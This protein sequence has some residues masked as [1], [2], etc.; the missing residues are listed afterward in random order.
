MERYRESLVYGYKFCFC[1]EGVC[2]PAVIAA[3][4]DDSSWETVRVPHDWAANGEFSITNDSSYNAVDADGLKDAIGHTGRTGG[5]PIVGLGVY[6]RWIDVADEDKG[7]A[8]MLEFDGVMWESH[9]YVNGKHAYFNHYGYKSFCVDITDLVEYGKPNL[10]AVSAEV[11]KDCSRWYC[12][13]GIYRNMYLVRKNAAHIGYHGIW[14]RQLEVTGNYANFELSVEHTG[15][16]NVK[17]HANILSPEGEAVTQVA[18]EAC[19]GRLSNI[20]SIPDAKLWDVDSPNL[21]TAVVS[22]LD[23]NDNVLDS[24]TVRFGARSIAFTP[25]KGFFL[26]GRS[27]K[28]K[29]VCLH[30]DLGS[31]G[32]AV[33]VAALR[34][35]LRM[36]QEM[37]ANAIRTSHNPPA[38][39]LLELCDEMGLLVN[40]ELFD[41]W[42]LPKVENGYAQYFRQHAAR[43]AEDIVRRD[44][45]HP[46]VIMW[47]IGNEVCEQWECD[48]WRHAKMLSKACHRA[49]PT[50]PTTAGF[51]GS[52]ASF[53][54][55]LAEYIDV[56]GHNYKPYYYEEFHKNH[57]GMVH[58][59][60][61]TASCVS[62]RGVYKLPA[63]I[64]I[65][66]NK[67]EDLTVS[68]YELE[69]P[70]WA[71][72]P[73]AEFAAQ[74]DHGFLVGEFV[75]SGFD[76][77]GEPTPYYSEWP[78]RSSY[79]GIVDLAGIPKN[80]YYGYQAHWTK[81]P[82]LHIFPHWNWEGMEG[83]TVPVH[84]YTNFAAVELFVNGKSYGRQSHISHAHAGVKPLWETVDEPGGSKANAYD[85]DGSNVEQRLVRRYR[86]IW[87]D[88]VYQPGT[89]KAVAYDEKGNVAA[90]QC[91]H[92]AGKPAGIVLT[93]DRDAICADG[94]DLV[95]ITATVVDEN[96]H[97]CPLADNRLCFSVTGEGELLT[98]DN[99]DQRET[100]SFARPDKKVLAGMVVACVRSVL[101]R[102][103]KLKLTAKAEGLKTAEIE[104]PVQE[105]ER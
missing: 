96:G 86:L 102:P 60:A 94:D 54:N 40:E 32:A 80:R 77:L 58:M 36:M 13:A 88:V 87:D 38:V 83:Q 78:S 33:N 3:D 47:S 66:C 31:L 59:G 52:W 14:L 104:I 84:V 99:G 100:E 46:C 25:D 85:A 22:L 34:R 56:V 73:E 8:I 105:V 89:V 17:L 11:K 16:E 24:D 10:I 71:N 79:F 53:D 91:I 18:A 67:H 103:G 101:N 63:G 51:N 26:N 15:S 95:Y 21:Y 76:Y 6:R 69:A 81:K 37:G 65:P 43:D 9:I 20:F 62:T 45:N 41:E 82:T 75:W 68:A 7:K 48:G 42:E 39:E 23:E 93:A 92:T 2:D 64:A 74:D 4:Y 44:R 50:R 55:H 57:P 72:F 27:L 29:G 49:D 5:L 12:G 35:Q 97:S 98:T 1:P 70:W 61:E 28:I 30:H 90:E 19:D